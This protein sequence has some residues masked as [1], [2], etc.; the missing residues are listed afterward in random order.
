MRVWSRL[1]DN[2]FPRRLKNE[3]QNIIQRKIVL[4]VITCHFSA[5]NPLGLPAY[6]EQKGKS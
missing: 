5:E 2:V 1:R 3:E 6:L 4:N